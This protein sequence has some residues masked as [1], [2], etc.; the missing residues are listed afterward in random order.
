MIGA[1]ISSRSSVCRSGMPTSDISIMAVLRGLGASGEA[2]RQGATRL[3]TAWLCGA[4]LLAPAAGRAAE[5][6]RYPIK[7]VRWI[8]PFPV[9]GSIDIVGRIV[10]QKLF[11]TWGRQVVVDNRPGMGG[12]IGTQIGAASLPDGYTQTLTLNTT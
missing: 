6:A 2:G 1:A 8:V 10:G 9:G 7:P 11:E 12:R 3:A 4:L 5:D